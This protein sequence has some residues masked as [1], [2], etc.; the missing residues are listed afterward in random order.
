MPPP[1]KEVPNPSPLEWERTDP[2]CWSS[3]AGVI[4][5]QPDNTWTAYLYRNTRVGKGW[6]E[7]RSGFLTSD[8]ARRW[9]EKEAED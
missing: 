4:R 5:L 9:I 1:R 8:K 2:N 7:T 6:T 3:C